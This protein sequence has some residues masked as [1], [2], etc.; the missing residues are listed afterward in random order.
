MLFR[1]SKKELLE[2]SEALRA[3]DPKKLADKQLKRWTK[4][5]NATSGDYFEEA[6]PLKKWLENPGVALDLIDATPSYI[7]DL[8][9]DYLQKLKPA[10]RQKVLKD[11]LKAK[12]VKLKP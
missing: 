9:A 10:L 4:L 8:H 6:L 2:L 11:K 7:R 12:K 1:D 5:M 3:T